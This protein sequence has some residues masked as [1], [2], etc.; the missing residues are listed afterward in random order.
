MPLLKLMPQISFN[1]LVPCCFAYSYFLTIY[2]HQFIR[3]VTVY[4]TCTMHACTKRYIHSKNKIVVL[5]ITECSY[6]FTIRV[7]S[8]LC[9]VYFEPKSRFNL[10]FCSKQPLWELFDSMKESLDSW[11]QLSRQKL[12]DPSDGV[13]WLLE[14]SIDFLFEFSKSCVTLLIEY[15]VREDNGLLIG[16]NTKLCWVDRL[17]SESMYVM[18]ILSNCPNVATGMVFFER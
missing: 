2:R 1:W 16:V 17:L 3:E 11:S 9:K 8:T 4:W 18:K 6:S 13:D 10:C 7:F 14:K 12:H 15:W 5:S